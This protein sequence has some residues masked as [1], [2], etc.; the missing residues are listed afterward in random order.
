MIN[1]S[2][3]GLQNPI[4]LIKAPIVRISLRALQGCCIGFLKESKHAGQRCSG[5]FFVFACFLMRL[6][7]CVPGCLTNPFRL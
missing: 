1:C 7:L 4:L 2:I 6:G 3:M 5:V